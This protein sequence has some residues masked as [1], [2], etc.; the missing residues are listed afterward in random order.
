M[1]PKFR[2]WDKRKNEMYNHDE[3]TI[4]INGS[5]ILVAL[6]S[7]LHQIFNYELMQST[8][9]KDKNGVEIYG[10]DVVRGLLDDLFL[11]EWLDGGFVL[12]EYCNWGYDH[13]HIY[14]W[15]NLE[16]IGNLYENPELME[17]MVE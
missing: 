9:F 1:I 10:K 6:A 13:Y 4:Q 11:V 16:V 8:G 17:E 5:K 14:D 2:V 12:T 7:S 15:S 3:L